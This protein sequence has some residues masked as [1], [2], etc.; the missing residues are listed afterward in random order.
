[1]TFALR[2]ALY[3]RD[4]IADILEWKAP[5]GGLMLAMEKVT[6]DRPS[7]WAKYYSGDATELWL[8]REFHYSDRI[9]YY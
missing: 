4:A 9:R 7:N 5:C 8:P 2:E 3:G 6:Q 1:M